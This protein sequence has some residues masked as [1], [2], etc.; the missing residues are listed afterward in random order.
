VINTSANP[1][2]LIPAQ[3]ANTIIRVYKMFFIVAGITK[4][5]FEDGVP[6]LFSGAMPFVANGSFVLDMDGCPWFECTANQ[7]FQ[8][9]NSG[10]VLIS[11]TV[12]YTATQFI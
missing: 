3:G 9:V 4:I 1:A 10:A 7:P 5:T 8:A 6:T 2:V 11:G 12:Y